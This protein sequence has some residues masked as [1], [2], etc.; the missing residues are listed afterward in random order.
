VA[1]LEEASERL[2]AEVERELAVAAQRGKCRDESCYVA[3]IQNDDCFRIAAQAPEGL[4]VRQPRAHIWKT[5]ERE[6][7]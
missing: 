1:A 4:I 3:V 5:S 7:V 6:C 2:L